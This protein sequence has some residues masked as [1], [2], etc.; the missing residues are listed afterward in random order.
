MLN[1]TIDTRLMD[2]CLFVYRGNVTFVFEGTI[3]LK[4][5]SFG[6]SGFF[7]RSFVW[8]RTN[9]YEISFP[10]RLTSCKFSFQSPITVNMMVIIPS[11]KKSITDAVPISKRKQFPSWFTQTNNK[12]YY[13]VFL[14]LHAIRWF[15]EQSVVF[16]ISRKCMCVKH[17]ILIDY[18]FITQLIFV[19]KQYFLLG[20]SSHYT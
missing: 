20:C 3:W 4:C 1:R 9:L 5:V 14:V 6:C 8:R 2:H 18:G 16:M 11:T 12:V 19:D 15:R 13:S 7:S 10:P 17:L